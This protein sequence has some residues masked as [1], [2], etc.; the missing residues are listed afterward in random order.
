MNHIS[1]GL[2]GYTNVT[3][4]QTG[5]N[6]FQW[7]V[8]ASKK[9]LIGTQDFTCAGTATASLVGIV[10][11]SKT[12][13]SWIRAVPEKTVAKKTFHIVNHNTLKHALFFMSLKEIYPWMDERHSIIGGTIFM[14]NWRIRLGRYPVITWLMNV[15]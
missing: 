5:S 7:F 4:L 3:I 10:F 15:L 13:E 6:Y 11:G 9:V 2:K 12:N 8:K 14:N 1:S